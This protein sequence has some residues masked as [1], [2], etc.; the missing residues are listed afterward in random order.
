VRRLF[1]A[2]GAVDIARREVHRLCDRAHRA[3]TCV[4]LR[5][6]RAGLEAVIGHVRQLDDTRGAT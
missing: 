1:A 6:V 5:D 4:E 3:A 2:C